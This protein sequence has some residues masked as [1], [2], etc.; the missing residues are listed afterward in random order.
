MTAALALKK[1]GISSLVIEAEALDTPSPG[2]RAIFL[3]R[4]SLELLEKTVSGLGFT[5]ARDGIVWPVKR[6]LYK[7]KEVY[8]RDYGLT[9]TSDPAKLPPVYCPASK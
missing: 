6:T 1:K 4:A 7:G 2:S 5:L 8:K 3:H 9:D